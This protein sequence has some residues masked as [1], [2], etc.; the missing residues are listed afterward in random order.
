MEPF[1]WVCSGTKLARKA[2]S[3]NHA[4]FEGVVE[5]GDAV[6]SRH[7]RFSSAKQR[8]VSRIFHWCASSLTEATAIFMWRGFERDLGKGFVYVLFAGREADSTGKRCFCQGAV[9]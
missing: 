8:P 5:M 6:V 1:V 7:G 4:N 2:L 3:D 9:R